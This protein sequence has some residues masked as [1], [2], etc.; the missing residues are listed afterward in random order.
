MTSA[1]VPIVAVVSVTAIAGVV[2]L[3]QCRKPQWLPGRLFL[4]IMN[5]RHARLTNWG[6][7][8]VVIERQFTVLDVG[9]G[10]GR[11]IQTLASAAS[12]GTVHGIDHSPTSVA[13]SRRTNLHLVEAGRADIRVG[14]VSH[15]PYADE[16]FDV[17][18]AVETLY[19][20]PD[21]VADAREV[22]RVVKPGGRFV[23]IA[24]TYESQRSE[25]RQRAA[26]RVLP[27]TFLAP[28]GHREL[29]STAGFSEIEVRRSRVAGAPPLPPSDRC[30]SG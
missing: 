17:V 5:R 23:V 26:G 2:L 11:T 13:A 21:L 6:L 19:Y 10:G 1:I 16:T 29:L 9:C 12:E 4:W 7:S 14:S 18:S 3:Q 15:L 24:E 28:S 20:W 27:A 22:L 30:A 8:H 25:S